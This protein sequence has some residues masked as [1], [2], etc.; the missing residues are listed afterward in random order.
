M[1]QYAIYWSPQLSWLLPMTPDHGAGAQKGHLWH[2][3]RIWCGGIIPWAFFRFYFLKSEKDI[4]IAEDDPYYLLQVGEYVPKSKRKAAAAAAADNDDVADFVRSLVPTFL[5]VDTQ[6]RVIRMDTFSKVRRRTLTH[7][8]ISHWICYR[9]SQTIAPGMRLGWFTCSPLFA[10]RLERVGET[11]TQSPCGLGQSLA[12]ALLSHWTF[13]G[14]IR[15][16]RGLRGQYKWRRDFFVDCLA[17]EFDLIPTPPSAISGGLAAATA[18]GDHTVLSAYRRGEKSRRVLSFVPPS[19]GM[20]VWVELY[21]GDVPDR[22]D[23]EDGSVLTPERQFWLRL[24]KAGVL[25][26]PGWIFSP[27]HLAEDGG[28]PSGEGDRQVGQLRLSYTPSDVSF[29][30][31]RHAARGICRN[32]LPFTDWFNIGV[33]DG[34]NAPGY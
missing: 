2:L 31:G 12:A 14:Y 3:R 22:T 1:W 8:L 33:I 32:L 23:E 25:A 27:A 30:P 24:I 26:A 29:F 17:E 11:S 13:D 21:F 4:I 16:L 9:F 7:F 6:G 10:E 28:P 34:D 15:W 20:F 18:G 5:R 19:A